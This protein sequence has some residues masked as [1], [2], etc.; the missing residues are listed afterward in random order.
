MFPRKLIEAIPLRIRQTL[1]GW[2]ADAQEAAERRALLHR[3]RGNDVE[4]NV[5]GWTGSRFT[6]DP[7]HEGTIC[8]FCGSQVRHRLVMCALDS[9]GEFS[10]ARLIK[11][12]D[13]LH[14]APEW[15]LREKF[16]GL[17]ARYV[18]ADYARED[19]DRKLDISDMPSIDTASFDTVIACDVLEHVREDR[20]ALRELRR[21][22]R[23]NGVA[24]LTVPQKDDPAET[25]EDPNVTETGERVRLF[26][27]HDHVRMYGDDFTARISE[28]GFL[29]TVIQSGTFPETLQRRHVL[30]PPV[31]SPHPLATNRRRIYFCRAL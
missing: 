2:Y 25:F 18:T 16:A 28:A 21:I 20:R 17:P 15:K 24:L 23:P 5:C 1:G 31:V 13:V 19:V 12:R 11:G 14:F 6:D 3:L 4:C 29:P 26:G 10:V 22:L 7:W 30:F 27:Q 9:I 8:P